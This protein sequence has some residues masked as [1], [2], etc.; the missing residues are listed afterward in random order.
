MALGLSFHDEDGGAGLHRGGKGVRIDYRIRSDNAWLTAAYTRD[1]FPPW[2]LEGGQ[3]GSPNHFVIRRAN[4]EDERHSVVS[5]LT[6]NTDD[7]IQVMTATGAGWGDPLE[8]DRALVEEDLKNEYVTPEQAARDYGW[9]C[10]IMHIRPYQNR[11]QSAIEEILAASEVELGVVAPEGFFDDLADIP[12]S[13]ADG[14]FL[15]AE[16]DGEVVGYGALRPTGEIVRMRVSANHRRRGI[17]SRILTRLIAAA[18]ELG[19]D[20]VH[21]HTLDTQTAAQAL[22]KDFGFCE[23]GRGELYGYDVVGFEYAVDCG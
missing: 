3:P 14:T 5:G 21:L 16:E 8:R 18:V 12:A 22:Y 10:D 6:L 13:F 7:V 9:S 15:V 23:V 1:K 4:G 2:P 17:A 11:D 20:K 19:F